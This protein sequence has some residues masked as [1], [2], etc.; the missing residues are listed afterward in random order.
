[1]ASSEEVLLVT[2]QVRHA[3][4]DGTLYL[5]AERLAWQEENKDIFSVSHHYA[6]I[7]RKYDNNTLTLHSDCLR[8]ESKFLASMRWV[9]ALCVCVCCIVCVCDCVMVILKPTR[10]K[11]NIRTHTRQLPDVLKPKCYSL[12]E[13]NQTKV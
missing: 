3:K 9:T 13:G 5:M 1:M 6:D 2:G 8:R 12:V 7:K 4:K 11:C 10:K